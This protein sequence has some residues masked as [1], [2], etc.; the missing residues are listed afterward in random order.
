M[1]V[2]TFT[3]TRQNLKDVMDRVVRDRAPVVVSRRKAEAVVMIS[4]SEWSAMEETVRLMSSP[5]NAVRLR[6]ALR[7]LDAGR[8][9]T[10]ELI[11]P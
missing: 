3:E 10:H 7:D 9:E 1:D 6:D 8:G 5:A 11:D 2:M 4:L